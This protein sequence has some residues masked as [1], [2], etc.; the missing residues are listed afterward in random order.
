MLAL[1]GLLELLGVTRITRVT[2]VVV[3]VKIIIR[4]KSLLNDILRIS[5]FGVVGVDGVY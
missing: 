5:S 3:V 2:R 4:R 1:L